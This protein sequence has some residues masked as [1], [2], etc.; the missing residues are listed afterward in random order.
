[1]SCRADRCRRDRSMQARGGRRNK[2]IPAKMA[3]GPA[4]PGGPNPTK[5]TQRPWR[6]VRESDETNPTAPRQD[7]ELRRTNPSSPRDGLPIATTNRTGDFALPGKQATTRQH[8]IPRR[9]APVSGRRGLRTSDGG[10]DVGY[11]SSGEKGGSADSRR[12]YRIHGESRRNHAGGAG[13]R[14]LPYPVSL[15]EPAPGRPS[16]RPLPV[17]GSGALR[18][19]ARRTGPGP[20]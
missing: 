19:G 8:H 4:T 11:T 13:G 20:A 16:T 15:S 6:E 17:A 3:V 5:R 7:P 10:E 9:C 18:P 14:V 1:M 12:G 2:A